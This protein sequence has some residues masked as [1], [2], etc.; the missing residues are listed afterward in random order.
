M[1]SARALAGTIEVSMHTDKRPIL[2]CSRNN[3]VVEQIWLLAGTQTCDHP[4]FFGCTISTAPVL[5]LRLLINADPLS[6]LLF[7][8]R[9]PPASSGGVRS[10]PN[11]QERP[12]VGQGKGQE[13]R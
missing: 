13:A 3:W 2:F 12:E 10:E 11:A 1:E 4:S 6:P 5:D 8:G 7:S 9:G